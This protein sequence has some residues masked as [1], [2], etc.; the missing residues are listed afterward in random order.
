MTIADLWNVLLRTLNRLL[1]RPSPDH[2]ETPSAPSSP[3]A[4]SPSAGGGTASPP[5]RKWTVLLYMAGDNGRIFDSKYGKVSLMAEMTSAGYVDL[6]EAQKVG[7]TDEVAI[8]AQFDTITEGDRT[9]RL[10]IQRGGTTMDHIVEVIDETN[11]GDPRTLTDFIVWGMHR[12]PAEHYMLVIWN[13][14]MGWKDDDIYASVRSVSR[15]TR[16]LVGGR[17]RPLFRTTGQ[18]IMAIPDPQTRGIAADD[19]SMDFLTNAELKQAIANAEQTTGQR[20]DIIGMDACLMAMAEVQYQLR[21]LA[22][23]MIASQEVEPMA[24]WPYT[25]IMSHLTARPEMT[26][27]EFGRTIIE[28]YLRS[29][30]P[31]TRSTS[32]VTQSLV[33]LPM[34]R[35]AGQIIRDFV[36]VTL[37]GGPTARLALLDAKQS[38]FAFED[39]EYVDLADFLDQFLSRYQGG[40]TE[41]IEHARVLR[42]Y[43][44]PGQG[45][46]LAKV[47]QGPGYAERAHGMSIYMPARNLSPFYQT[48]DFAET[49]W[50]DL[51]RW[52]N[53]L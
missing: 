24:G 27:E 28:E 22:D 18:K 13:H 42:E 21:D 20:L 39:P 23:Y 50:I 48:I 46:I 5:R 29:Y 36:D 34:M 3:P 47:A 51:I 11:C 45:P 33:H 32:H 14:G 9:Y 7:S 26:P 6:E 52:I 44:A 10:E 43:L 41:V 35:Q 38:A 16:P 30:T 4:S 19:T 2:H 37:Q 17:A 25:S 8:L 1:G 49:R 15:A 12:R 53:G 40:D 31:A